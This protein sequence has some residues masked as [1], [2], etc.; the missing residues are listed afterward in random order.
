MLDSLVGIDREL[1]VFLNEGTRNWLFDAVLP[2]LTDIN[3]KPAGIAILAILWLLLL[4]KG[5]RPGMIAALLLIPTIALSDQLN[6]SI[7]KFIIDRPRPCHELANVRALSSLGAEAAIRS[8]RPMPSRQLRGST[9][10]FVFPAPLDVG[11][12]R[13]CR[14]SLLSPESMS[15]STILLMSLPVQ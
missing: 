2:F 13:L 3:R 9:R 12:L 5:G 7:L 6:S 15:A 14:P 8:P 4:T 10:P 1:F 11:I